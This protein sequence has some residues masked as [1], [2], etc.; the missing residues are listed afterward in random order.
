MYPNVTWGHFLGL[1]GRPG[2]QN[3]PNF[4]QDDSQICLS[5]QWSQKCVQSCRWSSCWAWNSR[6]ASRKADLPV[7]QARRLHPGM[8]WASRLSMSV[9]PWRI[10]GSPDKG[11]HG[12]FC[13]SHQRCLDL[14]G[15]VDQGYRLGRWPHS[16]AWPPG[17]GAMKKVTEWPKGRVQGREHWP[18]QS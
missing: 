11:H 17:S 15:I 16:A 3:L 18:D 2:L 9:L 14:R 7:L 12:W 8:L 13:F 4:L 5:L 6:V 1:G 10:T